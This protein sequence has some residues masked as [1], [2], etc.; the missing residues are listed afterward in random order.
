MTTSYEEEVFR[1]TITEYF[2]DHGFEFV[3]KYSV[4]VNTGNRYCTDTDETEAWLKKMVKDG[5]LV[6][7]KGD[8][9]RKRVPI[10]DASGCEYEAETRMAQ[11]YYLK[12]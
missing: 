1:D 11:T 8:D 10:E 3:T 12:R 2:Y 9:R 6:T 7:G 4:Y 5:L